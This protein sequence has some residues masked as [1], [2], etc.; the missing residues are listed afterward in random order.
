MWYRPTIA[1]LPQSHWA[2][3]ATSTVDLPRGEYTLRA[4]SDDAV[5]IWVDNVL[6]I[7]HWDPHESLVDNARISAGHHELKVRYL[8]VEGWVELRVEIV[9]GRVRSQGSPGPH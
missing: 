3:E 8:Q 9:R 1:G 4:I 6:V 5:R 2:L 7:D